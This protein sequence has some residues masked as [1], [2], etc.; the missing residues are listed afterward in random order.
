MTQTPTRYF[1]ADTNAKGH[2]YIQM[3]ETQWDPERKRTRRSAKRYVGRLFEGGRVVSSLSFLES[4]PEYA[5][6]TLF[7][8][9]DNELVDEATYRASLARNEDDDEFDFCPAATPIEKGESL[10]VGLTWSIETFAHQSGI[11]QSLV[12]V[13]GERYAGLLL[14]LA[15]YKIDSQSVAMD[16]DD[17][18]SC[19]YLK[20]GETL[21]DIDIDDFL[22]DTITPEQVN[23]YFDLRQA[24]KRQMGHKATLAF[25]IDSKLPQFDLIESGLGYDR[26]LTTLFV[27]DADGEIL[28]SAHTRGHFPDDI[29]LAEISYQAKKREIEMSNVTLVTDRD[30][31]S[32]GK[33]VRFI[34][35]YHQ[36]D[37]KLKSLIFAHVDEAISYQNYDLSLD[38]NATSVRDNDVYWHL[39][40]ALK[41]VNVAATGLRNGVEDLIA[42]LEDEEEVS[43]ATRYQYQRFIESSND[44]MGTA[45]HRCDNEALNQAL[46]TVGCFAIRS[47]GV[48]DPLN[49]LKTYRLRKTY[50]ESM[51]KLFAWLM[52]HAPYRFADSFGYW[53]VADLAMSLRSMILVHATRKAYSLLGSDYQ[54]LPIDVLFAKLR[55]ITATK[56]EKAN[57]WVVCELS[58]EGK[59]Q[60]RIALKHMDLPEMPK[61]LK[62]GV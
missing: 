30:P 23:A 41:E 50:T 20:C 25:D 28:W 12:K 8:S 16:Y 58:G 22:I 11:W 10:Q 53:F 56:R 44:F 1:F 9:E 39:Y 34:Q 43:P 38:I 59:M 6:K 42:S 52:E 57:T 40:H 18:L 3:Y 14:S 54:W 48:D 5:G 46:D 45:I 27:D 61:A 35:G 47:N 49:A 60:E 4:F 19:V 17:W 7:F 26:L 37:E 15:I 33:L 31:K 62:Q 2:T 29:A 36:F 13:F 32:L 21:N 55:R 24:M 51:D